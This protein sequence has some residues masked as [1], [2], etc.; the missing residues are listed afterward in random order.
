MTAHL[1]QQALEALSVSYP[2]DRSKLPEH[3]AVT[4]DL[5]AAIEQVMVVQQGAA[6]P[7]N[8]AKIDELYLECGREVAKL[9]AEDRYTFAAWFPIAIRLA[10]KAHKIGGDK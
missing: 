5:R 7:L 3:I 2:T 6:E 1:L 4:K 8:K 9:D 10:E